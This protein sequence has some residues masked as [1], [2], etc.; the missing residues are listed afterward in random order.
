MLLIVMYE[1]QTWRVRPGEPFTFGRA[2]DCSAV[3]PAADRGV[4]LAAHATQ[5]RKKPLAALNEP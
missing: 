3:L 2:P 1:A 5:Y 4:S